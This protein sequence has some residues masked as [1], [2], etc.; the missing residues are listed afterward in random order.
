M[1][2]ETLFVIAALTFAPIASVADSTPDAEP[3][4]P[5]WQ[6]LA[7]VGVI[8]IVTEDADGDPRT[9][10]IWFVLVDGD[11]YYRTSG[12]RWL[13]NLRRDPVHRVVIEDREY[14]ARADVVT[15]DTWIERVDAASREKY[16]WQDR[17][18]R[19]FRTAPPDL[20][21]VAPVD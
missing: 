7:D 10:P 2:C 9:T 5:D 21:R 16:G 15:D 14:V 18:I 12:S 4:Y 1:R 3:T 6:A 13:E 19:F 8:D 20:L 17:F 11:P